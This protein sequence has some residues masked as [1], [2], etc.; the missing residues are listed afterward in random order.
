MTI[1][2]PTRKRIAFTLIELTVAIALL[3]LMAALLLPAIQNARE[4]SRSAACR[5]NL[6]QIGIALNHYE[7]VHES[8]PKGVEGRFDP[9]VSPATMYGFSWWAQVLPFLEQADIADQL[10][11]TGA[12][13]GYV[14]LNSHNG[15]L[16]D[17]FAPSGWYCP[18]SPV[19]KFVSAGLYQ[20]AAPSYCG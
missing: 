9:M 19:E 13:I 5:N 8:F 16:A 2:T 18:S 4:S 14:Q 12:N 15:A 17:G 6:K 7:S 1:T 10:D 3:A 11:H 20:I